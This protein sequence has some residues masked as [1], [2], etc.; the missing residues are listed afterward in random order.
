MNKSYRSVWNQALGAW[1]AI[2]EVDRACGHGRG[3]RSALVLAG[4]L[5]LATGASAQQDIHY[6]DGQVRA[7]AI[8]VAASTRQVLSI[9]A[10]DAEANQTGLI[11]GAG[12]IVKQGAG[13]LVLGRDFPAASSANTHTGGTVLDEGTLAVTHAGWLCGSATDGVTVAI[14]RAPLPPYQPSR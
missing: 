1:V 12:T 6:L 4:A 11:S 8:D 3:V 14:L 2:S 9:A 10:P 13:T 5:V 7:E